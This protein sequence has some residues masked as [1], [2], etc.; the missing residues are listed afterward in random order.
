LMSSVCFFECC[1]PSSIVN[2][3]QLQFRNSLLRTHSKSSCVD[4]IG[5]GHK[6]WTFGYGHDKDIAEEAGCQGVGT[7]P[8][9]HVCIIVWKVHYWLHTCLCTY[10]Y[11]YCLATNPHNRLVCGLAQCSVFE[12]LYW[13]CSF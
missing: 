10:T 3:H 12:A 1:I 4:H 9:E 11:I 7:R 13:P 8:W 5:L 6:T 2:N